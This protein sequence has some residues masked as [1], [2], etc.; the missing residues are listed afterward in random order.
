[1]KK[2][3]IYLAG[4][5]V[6]VPNCIEILANKKKE[7]CE[8]YGFEGMFPLDNVLDLENKTAQECGLAIAKANEVMIRNADV[9]IA[10]LTPFRGVSADSGTI[11]EVGVAVALGKIVY[12][13]SNNT[14]PFS[15]RTTKYYEEVE[16]IGSVNFGAEKYSKITL[17][18]PFGVEHFELPDNLMIPNGIFESGGKFIVGA[19]PKD[20]EMHYLENFEKCLVDLKNKL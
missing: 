12:G 13:Y 5:D 17:D 9:V 16:N 1:M 4:P 18:S 20:E 15:E 14:I 10:N 6:F 11:Y 19:S 8:K 7:L 3:K 2:Y